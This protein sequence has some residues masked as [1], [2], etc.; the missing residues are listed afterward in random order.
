[1]AETGDAEAEEGEGDDDDGGDTAAEEEGLVF[2]LRRL[3]IEIFR[4]NRG[5]DVLNAM[6]YNIDNAGWEEEDDDQGLAQSPRFYPRIPL[7]NL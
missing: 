5:T 7:L 2:D 1:M 6:D 4:K 3:F